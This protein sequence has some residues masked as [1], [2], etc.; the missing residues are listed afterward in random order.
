MYKYKIIFLLLISVS[1]FSLRLSN[2]P[3][4]FFTNFFAFLYF[5]ISLFLAYYNCSEKIYDFL[6]DSLVVMNNLLIYE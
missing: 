6:K 3:F 2:T 1:I 5:V 4:L